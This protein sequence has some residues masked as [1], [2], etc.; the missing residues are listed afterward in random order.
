[1]FLSHAR[2]ILR[3]RVAFNAKP[4]APKLLDP[5]ELWNSMDSVDNSSTFCSTQSAPGHH[6]PKIGPITFS[7]PAMCPHCWN[8][9]NTLYMNSIY[10][11]NLLLPLAPCCVIQSI[12]SDHV[13]SN[14]SQGLPND[15][16][17]NM[18]FICSSCSCECRVMRIRCFGCRDAKHGMK[19]RSLIADIAYSKS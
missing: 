17:L 8:L 11:N 18:S 19:S 12:F 14:Q 9:H 10:P 13:P 3:V 5:A 16:C 15:D 7:G 1:M 2:L 6:H 4:Y